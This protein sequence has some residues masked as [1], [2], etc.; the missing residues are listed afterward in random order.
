MFM[1]LYGQLRE[2]PSGTDTG[3]IVF[4]V[5]TNDL[6]NGTECACSKI[7]DDLEEVVSTVM[8]S[9]QIGL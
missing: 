8:A 1:G 4:P 5:F 3:P 6:H 7:L 9:V 2:C